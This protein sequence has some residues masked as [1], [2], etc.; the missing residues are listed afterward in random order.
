MTIRRGRRLA[1]AGCA[2]AGRWSS[3]RTIALASRLGE[4]VDQQ[5]IAPLVAAVVDLVEAIP[6][7]R[8]VVERGKCRATGCRIG[9]VIELQIGDAI[10]RGDLL[11][12]IEV[13]EGDHHAQALAMK[14]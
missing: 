10:A 6:V 12:R 1:A 4:G 14:G 11:D 2:S 8:A 13:I 7:V 9:Q 3:V 5:A